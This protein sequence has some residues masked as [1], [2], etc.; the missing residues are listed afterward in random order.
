MYY[1]ANDNFLSTHPKGFQLHISVVEANSYNTSPCMISIPL[2]KQGNPMEVLWSA[3]LNHWG[4]MTHICINN[5]TSIGS[6]NGLSPGRRQAIF[7]TN[8]GILLIGPL[9]TNFSEISIKIHILSFKKMHLKTPSGKWRPFC[10]GLN[11]LTQHDSHVCK[12]N[13]KFPLFCWVRDPA[14]L[15]STVW[16]VGVSLYSVTL[17]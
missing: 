8:A 6:D 2:I 15:Y 3:H 12:T 7:C 5:Q 17:W 16:L 11:V 14:M 1:L 13:W 10:L 4:R 9:G